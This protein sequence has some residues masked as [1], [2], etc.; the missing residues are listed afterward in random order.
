[1]MHLRD[2]GTETDMRTK[3]AGHLVFFKTLTGWRPY[4]YYY[5]YTLYTFQ[6]KA[7]SY[8]GLFDLYSEIILEIILKYWV[9]IILA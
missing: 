5:F 8:P 9:Q 7:T 2:V 1:M 4:G 6:M 3:H